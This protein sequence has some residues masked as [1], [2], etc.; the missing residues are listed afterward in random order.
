MRSRYRCS[1][2]PAIH[3]NSRS[4]L[5]SSSTHE[6]SDPP[7]R[8]LLSFKYSRLPPSIE[9]TIDRLVSHG[10]IDMT[11]AV[12]GNAQRDAR[13]G[14]RRRFFKPRQNGRL[15]KVPV[16]TAARAVAVCVSTTVRPHEASAES[17]RRA[18]PARFH[19]HSAERPRRLRMRHPSNLL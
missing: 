5:R 12:I 8:V 10:T 3:I 16:M 1:M 17:P 4:W 18:H 11:E 9:A 13:P 19:P 6:P 14:D 15:M 7:P 2:C